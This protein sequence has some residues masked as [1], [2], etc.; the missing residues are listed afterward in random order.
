MIA[1]L[2]GC[3]RTPAGT[4][5]LTIR[6]MSFQ[7]VFGGPIN[8]NYY[9]FVAIDTT[10]GGDGP[11][12]VFPSF[13]TGE[14]W[15]TGSATHYVEYRQRQY[16]VYRI[17]SMDPFRSEPIGAPVR[18][19][20]PAPGS[21]TLAFTIDLNTIGATSDSVDVNIISVDQP[22]SDIRL[23]DGLGPTGTQYLGEVDI[24]T[25]RTISNTSEGFP[26]EEP[27]DV[28]DQDRVIQTPSDQTRPLDIIDWSI[29]IDV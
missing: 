18:S 26:L 23:L 7:I 5:S 27:D 12:P 24:L 17:V 13:T 19:T 16:T 2:A 10:G 21:S 11:T 22:F 4:P 3:A 20:P 28:L 1:A 15:V 9:Y 29:T 14:G 25:D 6:E 8:D